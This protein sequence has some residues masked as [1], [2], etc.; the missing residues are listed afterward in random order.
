MG[1]IDIPVN[2]AEEEI[3]DKEEIISICQSISIPPYDQYIL[4]IKREVKDQAQLFKTETTI[5]ESGEI[6]LTNLYIL[7][8]SPKNIKISIYNT[9]GKV[10]EI[11]KETIIRYLTTGVEDQPPNYILDFSQ[12]CEYVDI[13]S[14]TIY[15]QNK[16]YLLQLE[17]LEQMNIENL[18][19]LQQIQLKILLRNFNDIF[20]SKN[21]FG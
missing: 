19:P 16:C 15:G 5:C 12:L 1:R 4:A 14:Q 6:G 17:Q 11:P 2:M 3:V 13:I 21:K 20:A 10:I 8:K 9:T 7:A 18:D